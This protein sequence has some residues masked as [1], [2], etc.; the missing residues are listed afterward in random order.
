M[1]F[2]L[3][4]SGSV[5]IPTA[6]P[7]GPGV[8]IPVYEVVKVRV[9]L[10]VQDKID[11]GKSR[12]MPESLLKLTARQQIDQVVETE[13]SRMSKPERDRLAD[14]VF[15][16]LFGFG[17]L[18]ELFRD[19]AVKEV[20]VLGPGAV[21]VRRDTGW[22]PTNVKFR[23]PDQLHDTLEKVSTHGDFVG[24][25][26]PQSAMDM[27]LSN[28]FRVVAVLPPPVLDQPPTI[29]F[30][31]T[32]TP[33]A[34]T[35]APFSA[36]STAP[37]AA[38]PV[39]AAPAPVPAPP[40]PKPAAPPS[41]RP[42][43]A[44]L[45]GSP[46]ASPAPGEQSFARHRMRLTERILAK[47]ASMGLYDVTRIDVNELCKVVTAYVREYLEAE[48]VYLGDADQARLIVEILS[49]LRR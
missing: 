30:V 39:V 29:L 48:R 26:L 11:P 45:V 1:T 49:T 14:E 40:P 5:S 34:Q 47:M 4:R 41:S 22:V 27:Q 28:G 42:E 16:E 31:R 15:C 13:A 10:K 35:Q 7:V 8:T 17:P 20:L 24:P 2:P 46:L 44:P 21:L 23:D 12:R 38:P 9:L 33:A 6:R 43:M 25:S 37:A 3:R 18:E 36:G 19:A 32:G